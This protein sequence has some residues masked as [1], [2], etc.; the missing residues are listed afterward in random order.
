MQVQVRIRRIYCERRAAGA[1][2][3]KVALERGEGQCIA[4]VW[5]YF[6]QI[7]AQK[8]KIIVRMLK[9]NRLAVNLN[10]DG[11]TCILDLDAELDTQP[12]DKFSKSH[13]PYPLRTLSHIPPPSVKAQGA[14]RPPQQPPGNVTPNTAS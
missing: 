4:P 11:A 8:H 12:V 7:R 14:W 3:Q 6:A 2:V 1:P 10:G 13:C 5:R 9:N